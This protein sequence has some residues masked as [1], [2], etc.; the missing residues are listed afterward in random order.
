LLEK[1]R[2]IAIGRMMNNQ[3]NPRR[4]VASVHPGPDLFR[5]QIA[6]NFDCRRCCGF[7]GQRIFHMR[8]L[9]LQLRQRVLPVVANMRESCV[10]RGVLFAF[11]Q[12]QVHCTCSGL[13]VV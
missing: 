2:E 7:A 1:R 3:G 11:A 6:L 8:R 5:K 10:A 9:F 4:L 13:S 12:E